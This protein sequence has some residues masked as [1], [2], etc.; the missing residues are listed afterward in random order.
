MEASYKKYIEADGLAAE[1]ARRRTAALER[2]EQSQSTSKP[3]KK[4]P[5]IERLSD[6]PGDDARRIIFAEGGL[7]IG[8]CVD[9]ERCTMH[10]SVCCRYC[11]AMGSVEDIVLHEKLAHR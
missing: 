1:I 10:P 11:R 2:Y 6:R 8:T 4:R 3:Q 7:P 9:L 5:R